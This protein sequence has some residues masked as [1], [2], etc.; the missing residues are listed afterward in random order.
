MNGT[1]KPPA[2]EAARATM[3]NAWPRPA[4]LALALLL[5]AV[6]ILVGRQAYRSSRWATRP[7]EVQPG[8]LTAYRVDLNRAEHAELLQLPGVGE[9][10][11]TR[12]EEY[13]RDYG[14]FKKTDDLG[15]VRGVGPSTLDRLRP[16]VTATRA[17]DSRQTAPDKQSPAARKPISG[18]PGGAKKETALAS[19]VDV[20]RAGVEELQRLPGIGPTLSQRIVQERRGRPF[21]AVDDLRRRV[22]GIGARK[23]EA[24][25]PYVT[26]DPPEAAAE[27]RNPGQG[28]R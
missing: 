27:K 16:W 25:R 3:A 20:N 24:L 13:R 17:A 18:R 14:P 11:A 15:R 9:G 2:P 7:T 19:P 26:V 5:G 4:Q 1:F 22:S 10:L 8:A 23:L 12:I 28:R 6:A 21:Q